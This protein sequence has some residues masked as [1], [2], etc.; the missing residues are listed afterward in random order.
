M[1]MSK[2]NLSNIDYD[3][4]VLQLFTNEIRP[5]NSILVNFD[6]EDTYSFF[7]L[8]CD[9]LT[10]GLLIQLGH[11]PILKHGLIDADKI[12]LEIMSAIKD[13]FLSIGIQLELT[14]IATED[15]IN[16]NNGYIELA[17]NIQKKLI[18]HKKISSD[19]LSDYNFIIRGNI[20]WYVI[21]FKVEV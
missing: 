10:K 21:N 12:S 9:L 3:N 2:Q 6:Q 17:E 7:V 18:S 1:A 4:L 13:Y 20:L 19:K 8:L 11:E 14:V 5:P 16:H 15:I